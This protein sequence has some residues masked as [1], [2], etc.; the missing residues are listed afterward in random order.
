MAVIP[1]TPEECA[2]HVQSFMGGIVVTPER[3]YTAADLEGAA[4]VDEVGAHLACVT[5]SVA[6]GEVVTLEAQVHGGG[7][8]RT[9]L[10]HALARLAAAG[11]REAKLITTNDNL[12]A[13]HVYLKEGWRL[14]HVHVDGMDA[15]RRIKPSVP[16]IGEHGI[17]LRDMFEF[18]IGT[19]GSFARVP[20]RP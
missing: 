9:A 8:G 14:V 7:H 5:W 10:R 2:A 19:D 12:G 15:V 13:I 20:P 16:L 6:E 3:T 18:R 4:V 11:V 1:L 17:P